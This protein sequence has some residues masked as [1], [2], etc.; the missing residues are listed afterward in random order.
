MARR[1]KEQEVRA[2]AK[3]VRISRAQG[4]A[5]AEHIRGR[6]VPEARTVL[7]FTQRAAA[8]D[9][10]KVLRSAVAN[11][12]AN[13]GLNGDE[14][15]VVGG[16]HRRGPDDQALAPA[17]PRPRRRGS[18]SAPATSRSSSSRARPARAA[19]G[20][21]RR[22]A[23]ARAARS[24]ERRSPPRRRSRTRARR[25]RRSPNGPEGPSRRPA[26]RRH[27]RLEVELVRRHEGV[28]G[29]AA[30]GR[31][32]PRAH[33]PQ[34]LARGAVGHPDPQGQAADHGRHLHRAARAS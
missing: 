1:E 6:S 33:L 2:E 11:A 5:R 19:A 24:A 20:R 17:R 9:I 13:H 29:D 31:Q 15:V 10:E 34:A 16:L 21:R 26:G 8:R 22:E 4:A 25:R 14:L 12:E 27:P 7:A 32:D 28:P 30:R 23:G 18:R 3:W